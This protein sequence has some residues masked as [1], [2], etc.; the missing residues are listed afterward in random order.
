MFLSI[1][2]KWLI[3]EKAISLRKEI[4][5]N[6]PIAP[7]KVDKIIV[8]LNKKKFKQKDSRIM[9]AIFCQVIKIKLFI[10]FNPSIT[11]GNQKWKGATPLF[12]INEEEKIIFRI[13]FLLSKKKFHS[14]INENKI[15]EN[16]RILDAKAWVKKY[17][18][19]ASEEN[20]LLFFIDRGIKDNKLISKPIHILNQEEDLTLIIVPK[21]NVKKNK[22]LKEFFKIKKKRTKTFIS[23]VWT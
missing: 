22:S 23:R 6:P 5:F 2:P 17:F 16:N 8:K 10:Q 9:G 18:N 4:W 12:S 13:F 19:E 21:I 15:I 3:E 11:F 7:I 20:K 14:I 1:H